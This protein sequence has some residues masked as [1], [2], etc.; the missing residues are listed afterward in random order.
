MEHIERI[1]RNKRFFYFHDILI[2]L[3]I[4]RGRKVEETNCSDLHANP[5]G[6]CRIWCERRGFG[7]L[8]YH[9]KPCE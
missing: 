4:K 9:G 2:D 7:K 6:I 3:I 8:R 1:E 5:M